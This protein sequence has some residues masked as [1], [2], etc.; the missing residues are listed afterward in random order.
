MIKDIIFML[1]KV[2]IIV[3]S[4]LKSTQTTEHYIFSTFHLRDISAIHCKKFS[5]REYFMKFP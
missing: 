3:A 5:I 4:H 2:Q 1:L